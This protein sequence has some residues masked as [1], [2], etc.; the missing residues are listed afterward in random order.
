MSGLKYVVH[1]VGG[2]KASPSVLSNYAI[3]H[4]GHQTLSPGSWCFEERLVK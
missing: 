2:H 4:R 1:A 3:I